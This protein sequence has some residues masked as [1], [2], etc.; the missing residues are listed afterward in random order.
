MMM[1]HGESWHHGTHQP[2]H[3][4]DRYHLAVYKNEDA[5]PTT[6]Y[7]LLFIHGSP[8]DAS[9][10][11]RQFETLLPNFLHLTYDRPGFGK[12]RAARSPDNL[13]WHT[14]AAF[15]VI[16][17]H[18]NT[19]WIAIGHSYGGPVAM[20]LAIDHPNEIIGVVQIG[21][22]MD[23]SLEK[24]HILQK[25]ARWSTVS[26]VIPESFRHSNVELINLK[27]D[28]LELQNKLSRLQRPVVMLHG[29]DDSLVPVSNCEYMSSQLASH[30][31]SDLLILDVRDGW[32]HFI[33]WQ[34]PEAV[35]E[36]IRLV[37]GHPSLHF[38]GNGM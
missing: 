13:S 2:L 12:S 17:T 30:Q 28:L 10:F 8:G 5:G 29:T 25:I 26:W 4:P 23:P 22:A 19:K 7:G 1:K 6:G 32:N 21:G 36:A 20:N 35:H 34:K 38:I 3:I 27:A 15:D 11:H 16:Q 18:P 9:N 14:Q 31:L 33:P 37:L 24:I